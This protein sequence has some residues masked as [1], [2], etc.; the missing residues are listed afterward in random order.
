MIKLNSLALNAKYMLS[1]FKPL[2]AA[3]TAYG[4]MTYLA[5][6]RPRLR[7]VDVVIG[8][9]CNL[10]CEH[11][12]CET[13][14]APGRAALTPEEWQ[15]VGKEC[16]DLGSVVFGIQGGEPLVYNNLL[17]IIQ[18]LSPRQNFITIKSNGTLATPEMAKKLKDAGV[19]SVSIGFGPVPNEYDFSEYDR[20]TRHLENAFASSL[21][22]IDIVAA[23][24][25]RPFI[26]VVVG[27]RNIGS[28][29]FRDMVDLARERG[30]IL[31][32]SLA[33][34]VGSWEC[35]RDVMLTPEDRTELNEIMRHNPH[36]RTDFQ[37][38]WLID[39]CGGLKEKIYITPYGDVMPCPFLH[40]SFGNVREE[41][42]AKIW[43]RGIK[44]RAFAEYAPVC[45]AAEDSR[46]LDYLDRARNANVQLPIRYDDPIIADLVNT[47]H[48]ERQALPVN[49]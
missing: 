28:K 22:S 37:S 9:N 38:N 43:S 21:K 26:S 7:Y 44:T 33:V 49:E 25:I 31:N 13:L 4:Y 2:L 3:R 19:D 11:C 6:R 32:L 8:Y 12:L 15:G 16:R 46:F 20:N 23:A 14:K 35:S 29:V 39:G 18:G 34:P 24:G 30:C 40:I 42:L 41:P 5:N 27:R 36:V 10:K 17:T 45:L 47:T 1:S 48:A